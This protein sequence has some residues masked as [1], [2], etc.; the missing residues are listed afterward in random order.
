MSKYEQIAKCGKRFE[1]I[2]KMQEQVGSEK[3]GK[4]SEKI[5][6]SWKMQENVGKCMRKQ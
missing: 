3:V 6:T 1:K 4:G 5:G 2:L